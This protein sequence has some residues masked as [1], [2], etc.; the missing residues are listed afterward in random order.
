[1]KKIADMAEDLVRQLSTES[2]RPEYVKGMGSMFAGRPDERA[3]DRLH[4]RQLRRRCRRRAGRLGDEG[5]PGD[6]G[7]MK[8]DDR[9]VDVAGEPVK[10]MTAYM[11]SMGKQKK[12]QPVEIT[13]ERKGG[14]IKLTVTPQ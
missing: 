3:A 5:R 11:Q 1:M 7:G 12:N 9:I 8:D 13:V 14:K 2:P 4:A 6:K 10:N